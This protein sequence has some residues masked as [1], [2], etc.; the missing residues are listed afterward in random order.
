MLYIEY[1]VDTQGLGPR[2]YRPPQGSSLEL[3][4]FIFK[5]FKTRKGNFS[6]QQSLFGEGTNIPIFQYSYGTLAV[7]YLNYELQPF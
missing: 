2:R 7:N 5:F 6:V 4:L 1:S 3:P